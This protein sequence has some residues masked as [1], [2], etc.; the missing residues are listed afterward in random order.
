[1]L[2]RESPAIG[3]ATTPDPERATVCGEL[4]AEVVNVSVPER[5]PPVLGLKLTVTIQEAL[6]A[7]VLPQSLLAEATRLKSVPP[8]VMAIEL[9]LSVASPLLVRVTVLVVA[10]PTVWLPKERLVLES[11]APD[12]GGRKNSPKPVAMEVYPGRSEIP[13]A[14]RL[15]SSVS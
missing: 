14:C 11:T 3:R 13:S 4:V 15:V 8:A 9:M 5:G 12:V 10:T 2:V 6:A 7:S 1:M